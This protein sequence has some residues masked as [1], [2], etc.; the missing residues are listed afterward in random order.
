MNPSKRALLDLVDQVDEP[1][2]SRVQ[3][4][5]GGDV[6]SEQTQHD[7]RAHKRHRD[8]E[9]RWIRQ[10]RLSAG[11]AVSIVDLSAGG[12]LVDSPIALRPDSVLTLDIE[13]RGFDKTLQFRVVRCEV[14]SLRPGRTIYRGACEFTI[15]IELPTEHAG[16]ARVLYPNQFAGV[17]VALK[18]LV[19]HAGAGSAFG[20]LDAGAVKQSLMSLRE[21]ALSTPLDPIGHPLASLL[22]HVLPAL[23]EYT[24]IRAVI[25]SIEAQLRQTVPQVTL[26]LVLPSDPPVAGAKSVLVNVP[27][28][29]ATSALVS[30]DLP[31]GVV[32][33]SWQSRVLRV[34]GRLIA[35]LQRVEPVAQHPTPIISAAPGT[36]VLKI[37]AS[38]GPVESPSSGGWQKIV[39]RYAEGQMLKGYTQ[40]FSASRSQFS[41]WP[42]LTSSHQERVIVPLARLKG[43]FFVRD[44]A[45]NPGYIERA[46][47]EQAQH[48]RRIEVT[49]V[50][51]EVI[52]GRTLTYRPDGHGFFVIPADP[53]ANNIRVFVVA[54]AVR[55][56]R[57]P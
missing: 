53:L 48:G 25:K 9:L 52:S 15:S 54:S 22:D 16:T 20:S 5:N 50:D 1:S 2:D 41:L 32:L 21:R 55:Q 18:H 13:G 35:L 10:A 31:R 4:A 11:A 49:L 34:A 14:G 46:E 39:V 57:F 27:G 42:S 3:L 6:Q 19:E 29:P 56:V 8:H 36:T 24:G 51:D 37:T 28:A 26:R 45:G 38:A 33:N 12:A 47:T 7:R 40:D 30:I 44:F 43:V 23:D 17:D